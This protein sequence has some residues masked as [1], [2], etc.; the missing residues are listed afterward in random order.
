MVSAT[1]FSLLTCNSRNVLILADNAGEKK[2]DVIA[3][4]AAWFIADCICLIIKK[5][6]GGK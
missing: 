2:R 6:K 1:R 3:L 4:E 5:K